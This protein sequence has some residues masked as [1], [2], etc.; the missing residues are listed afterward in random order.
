MAKRCRMEIKRLKQCLADA[1]KENFETSKKLQLSTNGTRLA[2]HFV[3]KPKRKLKKNK[4]KKV[5]CNQYRS[6]FC[7]EQ[8]RR[9]KNLENINWCGFQHKNVSTENKQMKKKKKTHPYLHVEL[10]SWCY[11]KLTRKA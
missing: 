4:Q 8:C 5:D 11:D 1:W 2:N 9:Q 7:F 10:G 3:K 6:W